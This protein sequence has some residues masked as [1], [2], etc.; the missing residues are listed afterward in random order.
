MRGS[1]IGAALGPAGQTQDGLALPRAE[2]GGACDVTGEA[3]ASGPCS[4]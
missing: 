4:L 3:E 2:A 1:G